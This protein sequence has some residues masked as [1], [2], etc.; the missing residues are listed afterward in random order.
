[1]TDEPV[2]PLHVKL[3]ITQDVAAGVVRIEGIT[4][5][6]CLFR[7]LGNILPPGSWVQIVSRE[8]GV[9]TLRT[10]PAGARMVTHD[11]LAMDWDILAG[12]PPRQLIREQEAAAASMFHVEPRE[13]C[14]SPQPLDLS[15]PRG[16]GG[17]GCDCHRRPGV[18]HFVP[19]CYPTAT[20]LGLTDLVV[21]AQEALD[22]H[23]ARERDH[24]MG[25]DIGDR[26]PDCTCDHPVA[27]LHTPDCALAPAGHQ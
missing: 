23:V 19:C 20:D 16:F 4:Y 17:C 2:G 25:A 26:D 22:R 18:H 13:V 8:D 7:G 5:A 21:T 11:E 12:R 15:L 3:D 27:H 24:R 14:G 10:A 6:N 1:M 9:L